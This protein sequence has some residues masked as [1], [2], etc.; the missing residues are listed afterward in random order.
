MN[1]LWIDYGTKYIW[2]A[3]KDTRHNVIMPIGYIQNNSSTLYDLANIIQQYFIKKIVI[4]YPTRQK[5]IQ[6]KIDNFIKEL[7][8]VVPDIPIEK[9]DEDYTSVEAG[10]IMWDFSKNKWKED[11]IAAMKILERYLKK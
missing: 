4:W 1:I 9:I 6:Q 5:D 7:S 8:F 3:K 10:A 2:L 11:T